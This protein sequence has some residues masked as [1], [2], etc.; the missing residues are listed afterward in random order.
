MGKIKTCKAINGRRAHT[1][2][3]N[4]KI[5]FD[6]IYSDILKVPNS[7]CVPHYIQPQRATRIHFNVRIYDAEMSS[8]TENF[9]R[10]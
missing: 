9:G 4:R 3:G 7:V 8:R 10:F 5:H 6:I 2:T 1:H